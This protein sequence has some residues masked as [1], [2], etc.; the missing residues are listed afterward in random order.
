MHKL[1]LKKNIQRKRDP[2]EGFPMR[3]FVYHSQIKTYD[4]KKVSK[5]LSFFKQLP[6]IISFI[7][8][9]VTLFYVTT[10]NN[11]PQIIITNNSSGVKFIH[12]NAQY[13]YTI[14]SILN[15]SILNKSKFTINS[16]NI[17]RQFKSYYPEF[18]SV[19]V[20]I[21]IYGHRLQL[22]LKVSEP[23]INLQNSTGYYL[24]DDQG[25]AVIKYNSIKQMDSTKL[26]TVIDDS[27]SKVLLG[28]NFISSN[29]VLFIQNVI[30]Q[31]SKKGI[32]I[33]NIILPN[34]PFEID[35]QSRGEGSIEK[36]NLLDNSNF[37]VGTYFSTLKYIKSSNLAMPTQYIDLRVPG[38]AF[39]K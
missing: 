16:N 30:Y 26:V 36:Y 11:S 29:S 24:L 31:Y 9:L 34:L 4:K 25:V 20:I 18:S 10:L 27:N 28:K 19:T 14:R 15:E 38:K 5:N 2:S 23:A 32:K 3:K 1:K 21:P 17:S 39:Y 12:S 33:Q 6:T 13:M 37:Q 7:V 22:V 8:I 35:V